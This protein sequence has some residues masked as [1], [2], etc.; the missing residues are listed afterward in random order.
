M[1][2]EQELAPFSPNALRCNAKS[3]RSGEQCKNAAVKGMTKCRNHG[4][5]TPKKKA[6]S[7][8][9]PKY[10]TKEGVTE[11]FQKMLKAP[12]QLDMREEL[13]LL[14]VKLQEAID[15]NA[16]P[17]DLIPLVREIRNLIKDYKTLE[18]GR[19][20][21]ITIHEIR[22]YLGL[23]AVVIKKYVPDV[24]TQRKIVDELGKLEDNITPNEAESRA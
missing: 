12:S 21:T 4:G 18:E 3:K 19:K 22:Q 11:V 1:E 6:L 24:P 23:V 15:R 8:K 20:Y 9:L 13:A 7:N 16:S 5:L 17:A 10:L 14:Q 2:M